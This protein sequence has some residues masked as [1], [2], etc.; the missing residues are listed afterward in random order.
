MSAKEPLDLPSTWTH[1]LTL[2]FSRTKAA[3]QATHGKVTH[4]AAPVYILGYSILPMVYILNDL[5]IL[6]VTGG[7]NTCSPHWEHF[8]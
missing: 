6:K 5:L 4:Q 8:T 7:K 3:N 1:W 2:F